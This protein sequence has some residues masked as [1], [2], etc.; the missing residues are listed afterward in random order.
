MLSDSEFGFPPVSDE[1]TD[2]Y[3]R[4][5]RL[6]MD[7]LG[8]S[9]PSPEQSDALDQSQTGSQYLE[10]EA[11]CDT[12]GSTGG[13]GGMGARTWSK[14][15]L[16]DNTSQGMT[17]VLSMTMSPMPSAGRGVVVRILTRKVSIQGSP[18]DHSGVLVVQPR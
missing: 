12:F 16:A 2:A 13:A 1:I 10:K 8:I 11:T 7:Y 5:R 3:R 17:N 15:S 9:V 18:H 14:P 4:L 6:V